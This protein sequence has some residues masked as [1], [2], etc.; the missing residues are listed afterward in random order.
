MSPSRVC[1][2][3]AGGTGGH[4]FPAEALAREMAGRGW[5]IVLATDRRGEQYAHDFP[6]ETRL[7]LDAATGAGPLGL[8]KASGAIAQGVLQ[9]RKAFTRLDPAIVVG[10]GGYPSAPAL[11]A[12]LSQ[13]RP[14]LIH[15]QNAVLG[16]TNRW[17]APHVDQVA[18][19]FPTLERAPEKLRAPVRVVGIPVR[20]DIRAL[21]DRAYVAPD[22]RIR[23][24]VTGGSQ[25]ARILSETTPRALAALP[26][27][28]RARLKVEQQTRV[29][30]LETAR[31]I[32][33]EAGISAEVA[34]FFRNMASRLHAA[35][36][37]IGRAGASTVSE[38]AVA[39]LP[40]ILV[41]LKIAT[42]DHQRVNAAL[43]AEAGAAWVITEDDLTV[44]SLVT[45]LQ[46]LLSN[47]A[48]LAARAAA[49]R[50]VAIPDAAKRLADLV[51]ATA[52]SNYKRPSADSPSPR[53]TC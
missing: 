46:S 10:F 22:Y 33:L 12:A 28:L 30:S 51:E 14:T 50:S 23:L 43:L 39:G 1:V 32:Y 38:L 5:R 3:A 2:L 4:M 53:T 16:R 15:E 17:L 42:D 7:D 26:E 29:E 48:G 45:A 36:L 11:L 24:L 44:D 49:A 37:V 41:P 13:K 34:P 31:Q 25:G 20:A 52:A 40:S 19:A 27:T 9:A 8:L 18:S 47:P 35:H 6:A 21:Y